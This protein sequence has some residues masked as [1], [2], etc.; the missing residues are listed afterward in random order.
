MVNPVSY[1][2]LDVYKRQVHHHAALLTLLQISDIVDRADLRSE[3]LQELARQKLVMESLKGNPAI[4]AAK[5]ESITND[6]DLAVEALRSEATKLG[7]AL[8]TNE[9]LMS[10]KQRTGIPGGVCEFDVPSYHFWLNLSEARRKQDLKAV[11]YTHLLRP[12]K[13]PH[14]LLQYLSQQSP[15]KRRSTDFLQNQH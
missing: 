3:L 12:L 5:L 8:R 4:A 7:Q 15:G 11:S 13:L 14:S 2:H 9:W 1:T 10:I 6:I